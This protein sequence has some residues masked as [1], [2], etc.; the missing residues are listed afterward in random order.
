MCFYV[1]GGRGCCWL[2]VQ[3]RLETRLGGG[4]SSREQGLWGGALIALTRLPRLSAPIPV[5]CTTAEMSLRIS[6]PQNH[7]LHLPLCTET[8]EAQRWVATDLGSHSRARTRMQGS[9]SQLSAVHTGSRA[10]QF[11]LLLAHLAFSLLGLQN[12]KITSCLFLIWSQVVCL[13]AC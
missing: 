3:P 8:K 7:R 1:L 4:G 2:L 12:M 9:F 11:C 6:L 10:N 5:V 13:F